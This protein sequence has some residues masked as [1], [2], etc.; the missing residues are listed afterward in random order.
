MFKDRNDLKVIKLVKV[1]TTNGIN[2]SDRI[3]H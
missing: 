3:K 2:E 1:T